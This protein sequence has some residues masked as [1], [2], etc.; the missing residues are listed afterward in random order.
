M[1]RIER[2]WL[3]CKRRPV[4]AGLLAAV[5]LI[6]TVGS[7]IVW[8]RSNA[9]FSRDRVDSLVKAEPS[10]VK[11]YI[12][13]I[14]KYKWWT[15]P[16]LE[17]RHSRARDD[18]IETTYLELALLR[19]DTSYIE[20]L[21]DALLDADVRNFEVIRNELASHK[22]QFSKELWVSFRN[23]Q[24]DKRRFRASLALANYVADNEQWTDDDAKYLVDT[25]LNQV[26]EEQPL[27]RRFLVD[28]K[29][30]LYPEL[31]RAFL[32]PAGKER[33]T[34]GAAKAFSEYALDD[35]GQ[36]ADVAAEASLD[37]WDVLYSV[38]E[39][40]SPDPIHAA[41]RPVV[42]E[43]PDE[44]LSPLKRVR[45]GK[46]RSGAAITLL[47]KGDRE[48]IFDAL[49][50]TD[51]PE[52]LTQFVHRC[53]ARGVT[54]Q[55]LLECLDAADK[56]RQGKTGNE[57]EIEDRVLFGF[58]LALGEFPLAQ[59][60]DGQSLIDRLADWYTNDPSSAIHGA[61]GWLLRHWGQ[62]EIAKKVDEIPIPYSSNRQWYTL[63]IKSKTGGLF[64]LGA[65]REVKTYMTFVVIP[66]GTY[67]I[68]SPNNE[69][70]RD[71]NE[72]RRGVTITRPFAVLDRE[73]TW[74]EAAMYNAQRA[75]SM[76]N[77]V[78]KQG[79]WSPGLNEPWVI[80]TWYESVLFC[81]WLTEQVGLGEEEQA[82]RNPATL[83][84]SIY[85]AD[86][87]PRMGGMPKDWP[88]DLHRR[89]FR[90]L[91]E[92]EWEVAA[93][94]GTGVS[95]SFGG[96]SEL[97]DRYGWFE[98]NSEKRTH[99]VRLQRPNLYGLFDM[100]GNA[101]EWC[102]DKYENG[103]SP[104]R[105]GRQLERHRLVLPVVAPVQLHP[106]APPQHPGLS[107]GHGAGGQVSERKP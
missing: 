105:P 9:Q 60:P 104:G 100:H 86:P 7:A 80:P 50:V 28:I 21:K 20:S 1:T 75:N 13:E 5:F 78:Q 93:R 83:D 91:T 37:Q 76:R 65:R 52:S 49:R 19:F 38:L 31:K 47:R 62:E 40:A 30:R 33:Q 22:E 25:L 68:G 6:L 98:N 87:D 66:G 59:I 23:E 42:S 2:S 63:E 95:W 14:E 10:Q 107:P 43:Q 106:V 56:L 85:P 61:T 89:G 92:S 57:R 41:L 101:Y 71:R 53:R 29:E 26:P 97:L 82:Y 72:N 46:R 18:S 44:S 17:T 16:L 58:L 34:L 74:A 88:V 69:P 15:L 36:I 81:R 51:D 96:D 103:L 79:G 32:D 24:N 12:D 102:H 45:F 8:E 54:P 67:E 3:W 77:V 48:Q 55:E 64:G 27:Y 35:I 99:P 11:G 90:L 39:D 73:V 94:A 70:E 4:V 84:K